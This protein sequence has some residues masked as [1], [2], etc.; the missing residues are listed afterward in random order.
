MPGYN[1]RTKLTSR[2]HKTT[3]RYQIGSRDKTGQES[4]VLTYTQNNNTITQVQ[5]GQES[6]NNNTITQVSGQTGQESTD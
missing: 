2:S 3:T 6:Q 5:T 4:T 1:P